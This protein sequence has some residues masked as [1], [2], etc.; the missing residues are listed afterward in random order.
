MKTRHIAVL[1]AAAA[2]LL[3]TACSSPRYIARGATPPVAM[4][5][6]VPPHT[7]PDAGVTATNEAA[8]QAWLAQQIGLA[9]NTAAAPVPE[10]AAEVAAPPRDAAPQLQPHPA[11]I[12]AATRTTPINEDATRAFLQQEIEYQRTHNP[13]Q[14]PQ[15]IY[16]TVEHT[17]YAD[18]P[19]GG[20]Y[21]SQGQPVYAPYAHYDH[22]GW[23][24]VAQFGVGLGLGL[25]FCNW[26]H[27]CH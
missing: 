9:T 2:A 23:N 8:T 22:S 19:A 16:Q 24:D 13:E 6:W 21:D 12:P 20:G 26:G 3:S 27:C 15:P 25:L 5:G 11:G 1:I 4:P 7:G 10:P 18:R 17:V 14:A